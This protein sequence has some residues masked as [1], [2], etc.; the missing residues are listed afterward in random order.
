[1]TTIT[2]QLYNTMGLKFLIASGRSQWAEFQHQLSVIKTMRIQK[3]KKYSDA[4]NLKD[5]FSGTP[6][7]RTPMGQ[8]KGPY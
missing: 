3:V 1:M 8:K 6:L 2:K 4:G 7:I 5:S